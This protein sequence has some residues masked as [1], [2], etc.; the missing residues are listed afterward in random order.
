MDTS[1][2]FNNYQPM[3]NLLSFIPHPNNP[4]PYIIFFPFHILLKNV[5]DILIISL[6][7]ISVSS[8]DILK[9]ITTIIIIP[10]N[11]KSNSFTSSDFQ[12]SSHISI[13]VINVILLL[14]VACLDP[15]LNKVHVMKS[16]AMSFDLQVQILQVFLSVSFSYNLLVEGISPWSFDVANLGIRTAL[17]HPKGHPEEKDWGHQCSGVLTFVYETLYSFSSMSPANF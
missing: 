17:M 8:K 10:K 13:C 14:F 4:Q 9:V 1:P 16:V 3:V 6:V 2:G 5:P 12:V 15:N 7:S 11:S